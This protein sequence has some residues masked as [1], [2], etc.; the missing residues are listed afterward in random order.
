MKSDIK[1]FGNNWIS[2]FDLQAIT[3]LLS[4]MLK[5]L[6]IISVLSEN[7]KYLK[8]ISLFF[9]MPRKTRLLFLKSSEIFSVSVTNVVAFIWTNGF[10]AFGFLST[11]FSTISKLEASRLSSL[12]SFSLVASF[13]LVLVLVLVLM[14]NYR[15]LVIWSCFCWFH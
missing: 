5:A 12:I 11:S 3:Y 6:Y 9:E 8:H 1:Q 7:V 14:L 4:S 2:M 10:I 15:T 13:F